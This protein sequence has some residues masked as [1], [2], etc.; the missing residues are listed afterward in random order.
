MFV[1]ARI[2]DCLSILALVGFFAGCATERVS[3]APSAG[4]LG[5]VG[6]SRTKDGHVESY[7]VVAIRSLSGV[8]MPPMQLREADIEKGQRLLIGDAFQWLDGILYTD[9]NSVELDEPPLAMRDPILADVYFKLNH[10]SD[11]RKPS[12]YSAGA[13]ELGRVYWIDTRVGL[14]VEPHGSPVYVLERSL[15]LMDALQLEVALKD[16]KFDPGAVDGVIDASTRK[17]LGFCLEYWGLPYRFAPPVISD[18][19]FEA[20]T[21]RR[22]RYSD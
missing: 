20:I 7:E 1:R 6:Q 3:E 5:H 11:V 13:K 19:M 9:W 15:S 12:L 10:A 4:A 22:P 14:L 18:R 17:A 2:F 8:A 21:G 16:M